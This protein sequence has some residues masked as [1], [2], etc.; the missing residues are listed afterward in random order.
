M[1]RAY[2]AI[3]LAMVAIGA[4]ACAPP[5]RLTEMPKGGYDAIEF[6]RTLDFK[7]HAISYY[8]FPVGLKL[9][10]DRPTEPGRPKLYCGGFQYQG[11][12]TIQDCVAVDGNTII[13]RPESIFSVKRELPPGS[14]KFLKVSY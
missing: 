8:S 14:V 6:T 10:A 13:I 11:G 7:D 1:K 9:I 5:P 12:Y 2:T 3:A 4:A